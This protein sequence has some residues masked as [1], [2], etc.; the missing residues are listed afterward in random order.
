MVDPVLVVYLAELLLLLAASGLL[1]VTTVV[2]RVN[3][4]YAE[5]VALLALS[6][7][8]VALGWLLSGVFPVDLGGAP[9]FVD[10][11]VLA[12]AAGYTASTWYLARDFIG[13]GE[14]SFAAAEPSEEDV[15]GGFEHAG[16]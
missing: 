3:L 12:A 4:L 16:K 11:L 13:E 7:F 6:F 9:A 5:A 10:A 14:D 1:L 8:F 15:S 2:Y